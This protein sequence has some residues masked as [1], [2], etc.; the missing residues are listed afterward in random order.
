MTHPF[1]DPNL[2][3]SVVLI[4]GGGASTTRGLPALI[5]EK[6]NNLLLR[7]GWHVWCRT[8]ANDDVVTH[9]A[10]VERDGTRRTFQVV[11]AERS[12]NPVT[13]WDHSRYQ[14]LPIPPGDVPVVGAS[15]FAAEDFGQDFAAS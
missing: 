5:A 11:Y 9:A 12:Y 10:T 4:H 3:A 6:A 1:D 2:T 8:P 13:G 15:D 7:E 14:L